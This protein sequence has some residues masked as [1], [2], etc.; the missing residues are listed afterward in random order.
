MRGNR[1]WFGTSERMRWIPAPKSPAEVPSHGW[2]TGATYLNGGGH[3]VHSWGSHKQFVYEWSESSSL[4]AAQVLKSYRD[5]SYGRGLLYFIDPLTYDKN[6]L[7]ARWADPSMTVDLEG[8]SLVGGVEP[9]AVPTSGGSMNDL[10]VSSAYY[11]LSDIEPGFRGERES[12]F[13]PIPQGYTLHLGAFYTATGSGGVFVS[14][15]AGGGAGTPVKLTAVANNAT[16]IVPDS[17]SGVEGVRLW[18]G[19]SSA[20]A[21]TTTVAGIVGRMAPTGSPVTVQGPW[22]GGMGHSG[23]KFV[24][25]PTLT[26]YSAVDGGQVGYAATFKEVGDWL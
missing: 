16:N 8:G 21:A 19:K 10:P 5:G 22:I 15:V 26:E 24:G 13:I 17:F 9:T 3:E 4:E 6:V 2:N 18:I 23:C 12:V 20:G 25:V 1:M 11:D 14:P 7:P